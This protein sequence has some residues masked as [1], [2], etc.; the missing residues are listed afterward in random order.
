MEEVTAVT[1][2]INSGE[3]TIGKLLVDDSLYNGLVDT[4][5][6]IQDLLDDLQLNHGN[7]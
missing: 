2:R 5:T 4:N 3:G 7:M 1:N 6:E